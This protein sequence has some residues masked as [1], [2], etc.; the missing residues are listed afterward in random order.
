MS[1]KVDYYEILEIERNAGE[2]EIKKSYRR[3]AVKYHPDKNP[4]N[5]EAEEKF[6]K[7]SE[8]YQVLSDREK[9]ARYD[10]FGHSDGGG[11]DFGG[12]GDPF[13]IF[14]SFMSG[15]G[16][17]DI[18]GSSF[19]GGQQRSS[20]SRRQP[21][22][23]IQIRLKLTLEEIAL[24][25]KKKIKMKRY[26]PCQTCSGSGAKEGSKAKTCSTCG[27][28]GQVQQVSRSLFG[29]FVNIQPCQTCRGEGTIVTDTCNSC[30][31]EGRIREDSVV[32]ID[33]PAGVPDQSQMPISGEGH[34]GLRAAP[35]G[36]LYVIFL[37]KEH[38]I[39][40]RDEDDIIFE[41]KLSFPDA[42]LGKE[43][44]VPTLW[45][46]VKVDIPAGTQSGKKFRLSH[47]GMPHYR[48]GRKGDQIIVANVFTPK[49]LTPKERKLIE[50]LRQSE[51][52]IPPEET[53]KS[54]WEK[55][56]DKISDN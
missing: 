3:L 22:G 39:F 37:E 42:A 35:R 23:D 28:S 16:F 44:E 31:G 47:K 55:F 14:R 40:G 1:S 2:D 9:R 21:G 20:G 13:D 41:L 45:G 30:R 49:N 34:V 7:V 25:G 43:V 33:I 38:S 53:G 17:G 27:G 12:S 11:F 18:F 24:G 54:F 36:D 46:P 32:E 19:G 4:G 6:K 8:A 51:N 48:T 52:M 10:R 5:S 15:S 50:Q 26:N 56:K 29:Q